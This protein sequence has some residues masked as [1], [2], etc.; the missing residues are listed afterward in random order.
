VCVTA[1]WPQ[2]TSTMSSSTKFI[3]GKRRRGVSFLSPSIPLRC[4]D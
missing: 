3:T 1:P 2:V 4:S